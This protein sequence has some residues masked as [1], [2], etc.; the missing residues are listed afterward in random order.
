MAIPHHL[1]YRI[2]QTDIISVG[3]PHCSYSHN[4]HTEGIDETPVLLPDHWFIILNRGPNSGLPDLPK[5]TIFKNDINRALYERDEVL[6]IELEK[7][8]T[9]TPD[10]KNE[11]EEAVVEL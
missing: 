3:S 5:G 7:I 4:T 6:C 9:I 10:M 1:P 8:C 2:I 11:E